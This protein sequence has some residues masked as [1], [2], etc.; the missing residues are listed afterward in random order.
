M[1]QRVCPKC[2]KELANLHSLSRHKKN[3][4]NGSY[5]TNQ[6]DIGVMRSMVPAAS[7]NFSLYETISGS[8]KKIR[9]N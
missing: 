2:G 6:L 1:N 4:S 5:M 9:R 7:E 3:C 8:G